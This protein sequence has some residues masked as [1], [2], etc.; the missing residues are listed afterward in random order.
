MAGL[1]LDPA[2]FTSESETLRSQAAQNNTEYLRRLS[3]S[4]GTLF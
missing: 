1:Q 3:N 4:E 2:E